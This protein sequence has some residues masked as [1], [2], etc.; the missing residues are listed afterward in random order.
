MLSSP[1]PSVVLSQLA[2]EQAA[3]ALV[4]QQ[5]LLDS[6][7]SRAGTMLSGA[8]I[9][10]SFLGSQALSTGSLRTTTWVAI[11]CF[12]VVGLTSTAILWPRLA[13]ETATRP[14]VVGGPHAADLD[15]LSLAS[16]LL[17]LVDHLHA[18]YARNEP[19][20]ARIATHLRAGTIFL[21]LE[22]VWWVADLASRT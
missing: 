18:S 10:T 20:I 11:A 2:F 22:V 4:Q 19:D 14:L 17:R 6:L 1:E 12:I 9:S 15:Q 21:T 13:I 7:R 16:T 8:A 5:Q 3:R